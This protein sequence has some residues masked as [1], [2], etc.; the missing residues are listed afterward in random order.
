MQLVDDQLFI[1]GN[2]K[3]HY[4]LSSTPV[5]N[6]VNSNIDEIAISMGEIVDEGGSIFQL[7][8]AKSSSVYDFRPTLDKCLQSSANRLSTH[9]MYAYCFTDSEL[10]RIENV[11]SNDDCGLGLETIK[12]ITTSILLIE[13]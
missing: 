11:E 4:L 7:F 1:P 2:L 6:S 12:V 3:S 5:I 9:V 10:S 13:C 8:A